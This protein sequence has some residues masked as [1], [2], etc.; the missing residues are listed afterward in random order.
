MKKATKFNNI[1]ILVAA[2]LLL[3]F[4]DQRSMAVELP[5]LVPDLPQRQGSIRN[6]ITFEDLHNI[7]QTGDQKG[8]YVDLRNPDL[9]GMI[10]TG[11]YPFETGETDYD[12]ARFRSSNPLKNGTGLLQIAKFF[13][14]KYN[15]NSWPRGQSDSPSTP[16]ISY[17]LEIRDYGFYSGRVSFK[18]NPQTGFQKNLT[19]TEGPFVNLVRSDQPQQA[20]IAFE[21]DN[22]CQG[23]VILS[24]P[25]RRQKKGIDRQ[26][27]P[28]AD[29]S[30][31][32]LGTRHE[33]RLSGLMPGHIYQYAV[34]CE[35]GEGETVRSSL[36]SFNT[37]P[38]AGKSK[39]SF[40]FISDSRE[41][42]GGGERNYMGHNFHSL[43]RLLNHAYRMG[44]DLFICGGDLIN[45]YTSS[46]DDFRL[47]LKGWKQSMA[48]FW[49]SRPV[50]TAMGNHEALLNIFADGSKYGISLDKWPYNTASAEAI[51][52]EQF[53][54]PQNGPTPS[55]TRRPPYSENVYQFQFGPVLFIAFNNN[56]WW[57]TNR[58]CKNYG[59]SPEGYV[60]WDQLAWIE[61]I[62]QQ[63][64]RNR[65]VKFIVLFAQEP[66][67][68]AGGHVQDAMWWNAN[69]N[70]KAYQYNGTEVVAAGDGI[71]DV[72][73]RFWKAIARSKKVAAV[74]TGDEHA[75]HR[76]KIDGSIPVG[77]PDL[78]D[79]NGD[80]ILDQFSPNPDFTY[81]T[82]HVTAGSAG[83][84][85]YARQ[86]VPW[87]NGIQFFSSQTGY[88]LFK[89]SGRK[90][91]MTFY[92]ITGQK[93][94]HIENLMAVKK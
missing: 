40:A 76:I 1:L 64:E 70:I 21:T 37:A 58:Q 67:F 61:K 9:H 44:A 12:Y 69:N 10:H 5:V 6:P 50:Y 53:W 82:W 22:D 89:V 51:F 60:M 24:K 25:F 11:P 77:V 55:D 2:Y 45:G 73:N 90:I 26:F 85:Y 86:D 65:K 54:N 35:T 31:D 15:A 78:D 7:S 93:L 80:G 18:G 71:I 91:S 38:P 41:G 92:T 16:T 94:D 87:K 19:I 8:L 47:Q 52:A 49:R 81:P 34:R 14:D 75:Y 28:D 23:T 46:V 36:Y 62:L 59:G 48:G 42:V 13:S 83:A 88:C 20:L 17:R 29:V 63:A 74:L 4:P 32:K 56:Y 33:V 72:R 30:E 66:V 3:L 57:T 39:I 68:P 84:P 79:L 43:S 27:L